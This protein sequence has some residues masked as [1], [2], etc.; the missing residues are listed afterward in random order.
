MCTIQFITEKSLHF[1]HTFYLSVDIIL[2]INSDYSPRSSNRSIFVRQMNCVL[3]EVGTEFLYIIYKKIRLE[4]Y[5]EKKSPC[6]TNGT[7]TCFLHQF[8]VFPTLR[9]INLRV[10]NFL[11]STT[12]RR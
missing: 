10:N 12:R 9:H 8:Y 11:I 1:I 2:V 4:K 7:S 5:S 6:K 3:C